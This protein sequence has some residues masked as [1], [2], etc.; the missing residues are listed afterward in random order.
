MDTTSNRHGGTCSVPERV[1]VA[2]LTIK[3]AA[4]PVVKFIGLLGLYPFRF[5]GGPLWLYLLTSFL[6][7]AY[8]V[9]L[10]QLWTL[11]AKTP[12]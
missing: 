3:S 7:G 5:T 9:S 12:R 8:A 2:A 10:I 1:A 4:L 11:L 6:L